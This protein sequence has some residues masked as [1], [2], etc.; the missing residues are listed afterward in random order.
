[1]GS[2]RIVRGTATGPTAMAA[3]DAAL[4]AAGVHNY[5]LVSVSSVYWSSSAS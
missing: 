2:I 3:Y 5:N 4:A 1:M